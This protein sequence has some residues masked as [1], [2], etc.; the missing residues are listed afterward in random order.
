MYR[1]EISVELHNHNLC[2]IKTQYLLLN[3]KFVPLGL[4]FHKNGD[5]SRSIELSD[6]FFLRFEDTL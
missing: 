6:L 4:I 2:I 1:G 5:I 3:I